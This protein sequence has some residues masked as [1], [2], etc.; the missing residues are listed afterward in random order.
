M[1][2]EFDMSGEPT[3]A[4]ARTPLGRLWSRLP[5][6]RRLARDAAWVLVGQVTTA[7]AMLLGIR[8]LTGLTDPSVYGTVNLLLGVGALGKS[9]FVGPLFQAILRFHAPTGDDA[10][11]RHTSAKLIATSGIRLV[12]LLLAGGAVYSAGL[13]W[14]GSAASGEQSAWAIAGG[15]A[16]LGLLTAAEI[17]VQFEVCILSAQRRQRAMALVTSIASILR[18]TAAVLAVVA[19]GAGVMRLM[20]GYLIGAAIVLAVT[21]VVIRPGGRRGQTDATP[22]AP[23][24]TLARD[25]WRYAAPLL[26][27][28]LLAWITHMSGRYLIGMMLDLRSAGIYVATYGLVSFPFLMAGQITELTL[29]P[30]YFAAVSAG[31]AQAERRVYRAWLWLTVA[32]VAVGVIL[33]TL[34]RNQ[35]AAVLLA[36]EYRV[37]AALMPWIALG[38]AAVAI[39]SVYERQCYAYKKTSGVLLVQIITTVACVVSGI[40]LIGR[41][42]LMGA[43]VAVPCYMGLQ[44]VI[45]AAVAQQARRRAQPGAQTIGETLAG[46][47]GDGASGIT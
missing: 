32:I 18:P 28:A 6:R 24:P 35:I 13:A 44:A 9:I 15:F 36:E 41:Y 38:Y 3:N 1:P 29:R 8:L 25:M 22:P 19:M 11:V 40:V 5:G 26:L 2:S 21:L 37:G 43:A 12:L 45:M 17:P 46:A 16:L 34:L 23:D 20:F 39:E 7:A 30:V 4:P 33:F 27:V 10:A 47:I 14:F 42:G 31:D